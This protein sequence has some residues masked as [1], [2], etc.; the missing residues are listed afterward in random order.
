MVELKNDKSIILDLGDLKLSD[1]EHTFRNEKIISGI[2]YKPIFPTLVWGEENFDFYEPY[3]RLLNHLVTGDGRAGVEISKEE[4]TLFYGFGANRLSSNASNIVLGFIDKNYS[5][6]IKEWFDPCSIY[7]A[8]PSLS[9]RS[10]IR[11]CHWK[12]KNAK[13]ETFPLFRICSKSLQMEKELY[14]DIRVLMQRIADFQ[15]AFEAE[16]L[17]QL[18]LIRQK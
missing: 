11:V 10:I 18:R 2:H 9:Q 14:Y 3:N 4:K 8:E 12:R 16:Q 7:G 5:Y 1:T 17:D 6:F 15:E 13:Y